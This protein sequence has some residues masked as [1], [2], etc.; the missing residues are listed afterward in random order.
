MAVALPSLTALLA[1]LMLAALVG[2]T[3]LRLEE[4]ARSAARSL[5][6]GDSVA[7]AVSAAHQIAGSGVAVTITEAGGYVRAEV[8]VRISGPLSG[9][10]NWPL[11][12]VAVAK[13]EQGPLEGPAP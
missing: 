9:L 5:A 8:S 6:R 13:A 7:S 12:A 11:T 1:V 2:V 10:V 3:Q 4:S